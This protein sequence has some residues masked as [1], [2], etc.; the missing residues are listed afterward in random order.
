M[1]RVRIWRENKRERERRGNKAK[2]ERK[3]ERVNEK[4]SVRVMHV[5]KR[6]VYA[7]SYSLN[8]IT[9][10]DTQTHHIVIFSNASM[11]KTYQ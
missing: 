9:W 10:T 2:E 3:C 5:S 8:R 11:I 7:S 6:M 1:R 4:K